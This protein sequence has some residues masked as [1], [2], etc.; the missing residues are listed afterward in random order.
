MDDELTL[1]A[2]QTKHDTCANS[3][4][5]NE[6]A[7]YELSHQDLHW[8]PFCFYLW[9]MSLFATMDQGV[10]LEG[11]LGEKSLPKLADFSLP[12]AEGEVNL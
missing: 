11:D 2:L 1:S 4:D 3:V 8:L 12:W 10:I 9:L 6:T 5:P 7:H